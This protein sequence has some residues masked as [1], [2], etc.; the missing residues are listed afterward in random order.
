[1]GEYSQGESV[2]ELEVLTSTPRLTTVHAIR[3]TELAQ[4]PK[5]LFNALAMRHPEITIQISRIIASRSHSLQSGR[6]GQ[7]ANGPGNVNLRTVALMP[8]N[9]DVPIMEFADRLK[10]SLTTIGISNI[11]L[12][13]SSVTAALGRH[14]FTKI[15]KLKLLSWLAE[16]EE[17]VQMVY[18]V[19]DSAANS[20]W[21]Q[22]CIRQV[23]VF[24]RVIIN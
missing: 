7:L 4:M 18:Y 15:G 16:Q 19:C 10:D 8:I 13:S 1:M 5:T 14:A 20:P 12:D 21:S 6:H 24:S 2:G 17:R 23:V 3:D 11:F 22:R 9:E